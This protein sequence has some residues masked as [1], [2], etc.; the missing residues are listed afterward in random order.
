MM[1]ITSNKPYLIRAIYDWIVDNDLTPYLLVNANFPGVEL[2]QEYVSADRII[3][4]I[5]PTACRGLHIK[6]DQIL[7]TTRFSGIPMQITL[8]P[9]AVLA[10]YSKENGR[11]ME[12]GEEYDEPTP[13][14]T[15]KKSITNKKD[16]SK[17]GKANILTLIKK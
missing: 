9:S 13:P 11:G 14:P 6:N 1:A 16:N 12:F 15:A 5:S 4:N 10:I 7:F 3:L 2:P 8:N 17:P